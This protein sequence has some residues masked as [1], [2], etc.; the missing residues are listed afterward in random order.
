MKVYPDFLLHDI[1]WYKIGGKARFLIEVKGKQDIKNAYEFLRK[2][3]DLPAGRQVKKVFFLGLGSNLIFTDDYFDG[4]ILRF[5]PNN[6]SIKLTKPHLIHA[7]AGTILDDVI[8][9][10]FQNNLVGLEWAGGL[11]GNVGA[12]V[13]G[14][15]GAFGGEIKDVIKDIEVFEAQNGKPRF[16]NLKRYELKFS[17][18][19]SLVKKNGLGVLAATF[20]LKQADPATI[21][22]ARQTYLNNIEYRKIRHPLEFPNCGSVFKNIATPEH[23]EKI[24]NV[25]PDLEE[26]IKRDWYGKVSMGYLIKRLDLSGYRIG[27][28]MI[29]PKHCNFIV[30]LGGAR[31]RDVLSIIKVIEEKF[32]ETFDFTPE[33]EAEVVE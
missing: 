23:V 13:R 29:S 4:A 3:K 17:Y 28:A 32:L 33:V 10:G 8:Q 25:Y 26:K 9:F 20:R 30:N 15:V 21:Q 12:A 14:N 11:P 2:Q 22:R 24:L 6:N 19:N 18:R 31:A 7:D 1:L 5:L 16:K 27:N